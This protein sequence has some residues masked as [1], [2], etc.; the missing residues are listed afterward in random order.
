MRLALD[1]ADLMQRLS[2]LPTVPDVALLSGRESGP[3]PF[4]H[5]HHPYGRRS[6]RWCCI[7]LSNAPRL[8]GADLAACEE[9]T[10]ELL[11]AGPRVTYFGVLNFAALLFGVSLFD[12]VVFVDKPDQ[13]PVF[14]FYS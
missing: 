12:V 2:S 7:D 3:F 10:R 11:F 4:A 14:L 13:F 5:K 1:T 9:R 8:S 6:T